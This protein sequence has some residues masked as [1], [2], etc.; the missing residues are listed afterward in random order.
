MKIRALL[1]QLASD[2]A[3]AEADPRLVAGSWPEQGKRRCLVACDA[4]EMSQGLTAFAFTLAERLWCDLLLVCVQPPV[5]TAACQ[6]YPAYTPG[7]RQGFPMRSA[8]GEPI[9]HLR[10]R[11]EFFPEIQRLCGSERRLDMAVLH[12]ATEPPASFRLDV[13]YFLFA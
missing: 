13:P 9:G 3:F 1:E 5:A 10:L 4:M 7:R 11:G 2:V 12:C 8:A 6:T